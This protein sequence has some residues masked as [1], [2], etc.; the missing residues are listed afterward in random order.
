MSFLNELKRRNVLRVGAAYFVVSWLLL[1]VSATLAPALLLPEWFQTA[2][3]FAL[4]IGF[5]VALVLAWAY[6]LKPEEA[7]EQKRD[8][9]GNATA[10]LTGRRLD[11]IIIGL[12]LVAVGYF[13]YDKITSQAV[14][15]DSEAADNNTEEPVTQLGAETSIAV[16][17]FVNMSDDASNEYF[18][19]GL[20]EELLNLLAKIPELR[21]SARTS[22][23]SF[24]DQ[25]LDIPLIA[26]R[27][28]VDHILEGSVR[29][30]GDT[31]RITAQLIDAR[32]DTQLW[33]D[34]YDRMLV[35][36]FAI[37]DEIAADVVSRLEV[38]L[39]GSVPSAR[40]TDPEA[41]RLYLQGS[42]LSEQLDFSNNELAAS[43][44]RQALELDPQYAPAWREL[45]RILARDVGRSDSVLQSVEDTRAVLDR[46]FEIDPDDAA[47]LAYLAYGKI[48][49][50]G[51]FI[52]AARGFEQAIRLDPTNEHVLRSASIFAL[53]VA[54]ADVALALTRH[55]VEHNPLCYGCHGYLYDAYIITGNNAEAESVARTI[56]S[57]FGGTTRD[58]GR[59]LLL[60]GQ[61]QAAI[62]QFNRLESETT[63]LFWTALAYYDLDRSD[64][65][66]LAFTSFL[67]RV[68]GNSPWSTA[69][70]YSYTNQIDAAFEEI[71][72]A[73]DESLILVDGTMVQWNYLTFAGIA[74][75]PLFLNLHQD[76]RWNQLLEAHGLTDRQLAEINFRPQI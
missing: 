43:L 37:Q 24:R 60:S 44:F 39:V 36:I 8:A 59:A 74:R 17:P 61:P 65:F 56:R 71:N 57:V 72:R 14:G 21:V 54:E 9:N 11:F 13:S 6:E 67:D 23:F 70:L 53:A 52:Q 55:A 66:E 69:Q 15:G 29:K 64:D 28:N 68:N 26:E 20:S 2:V 10:R 41:F 45:A 5:P 40:A 49:Y 63:R 3:A 4:I 32:T 7:A 51:N 22:S 1:Q 12:L 35:D 50:D 38:T 30:S 27:L 48:R 46:A 42:Y 73:L 34:S 76:P 25:N 33:S 19:D 47:T 58:V 75:N 16:L 31:V 18:S 62:E